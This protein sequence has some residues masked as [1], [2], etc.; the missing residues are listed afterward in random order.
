MSMKEKQRFVCVFEAK[1][2]RFLVSKRLEFSQGKLLAW[3]IFFFFCYKNILK[4]DEEEQMK[5]I[6]ARGKKGS[7]MM[8]KGE[9]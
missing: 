9:N 1:H 6:G 7:K 3:C 2:G 8:A 4:D 5:W